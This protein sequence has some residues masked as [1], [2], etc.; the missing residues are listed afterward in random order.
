[1]RLKPGRSV[2]LFKFHLEH[3]SLRAWKMDRISSYFRLPSRRF[4][5][6]H[7]INV[8]CYYPMTIALKFGRNDEL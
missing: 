1:M 6:G 2:I 4:W 8:G 3:K 7:V 5:S